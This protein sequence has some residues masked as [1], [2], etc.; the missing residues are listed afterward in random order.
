MNW[1]F[2]LSPQT[3]FV[4]YLATNVDK[5]T[6]S[7]YFHYNTYKDTDKST[8]QL[9]GNHS[10]K[11]SAN[12]FKCTPTRRRWAQI[13]FEM[14]LW[15]L[16]RFIEKPVKFML[17]RHAI[18]H[19]HTHVVSAVSTTFKEKEKNRKHQF[20]SGNVCRQNRHGLFE[21]VCVWVCVSCCRW[22]CLY[23]I[24]SNRLLSS[25]IWIKHPKTRALIHTH[26]N[27]ISTEKPGW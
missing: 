23:M 11:M 1:C 9:S 24:A 7:Q 12:L 5:Q 4:F 13:L 21:S 8:Q 2:Q 14:R 22:T 17:M 27:D 15:T 26:T 20:S 25:S 16:G 10:N 6:E 19:T 18:H 3:Q